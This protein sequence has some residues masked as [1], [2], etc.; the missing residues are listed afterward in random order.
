MTT[1]T[2]LTHSKNQYG[3]FIAYANGET[4]I[5]RKDSVSSCTD[6]SEAI[7]YW[8]YDVRNQ[9]LTVQYRKSDTFYRYEEVPYAVIFALL[10]AESLGAY[11]AKEVKPNYGVVKI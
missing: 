4:A 1:T 6:H 7:R 9:T 11:I 10:T 8:S 3:E 5:V 2:T